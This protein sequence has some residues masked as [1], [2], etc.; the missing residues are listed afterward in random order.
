MWSILS[1]GKVFSIERK[2][3]T[4]LFNFVNIFIVLNCI[5]NIIS[6]WTSKF[7]F[8]MYARS[9][10][11]DTLQVPS[12][13]HFKIQ[14]MDSRSTSMDIQFPMSSDDEEIGLG[15]QNTLVIETSSFFQTIYLWIALK[16]L[17][18]SVVKRSVKQLRYCV[19]LQST[20]NTDLQNATIIIM[21]FCFLHISINWNK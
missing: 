18:S 9:P 17:S 5:R 12:T 16:R 1:N 10:R 6:L 4:F 13:R 11:M 20:T 21:F 19:A 2:K 8:K 3:C 7:K 14:P 15:Y